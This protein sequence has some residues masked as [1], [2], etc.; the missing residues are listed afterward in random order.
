[1]KGYLDDEEKRKEAFL[2]NWYKTGL[3]TLN[4]IN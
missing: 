3:V 2:D 4:Q 1:M